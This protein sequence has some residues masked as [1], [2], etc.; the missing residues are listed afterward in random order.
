M[1]IMKM[2]EGKLG[3][4]NFVK[5]Y[6][7]NNMWGMKCYFY[8]SVV[9]RNFVFF[10]KNYKNIILNTDKKNIYHFYYSNEIN[11][12]R[13]D[14]TMSIDKDDKNIEKRNTEFKKKNEIKFKS[15]KSFFLG[16][17]CFVTS[18]FF[19][20]TLQKVPEG[21][22][23]LLENKKDKTV[24]PYIYDDLMTFFF[25]SIKYNVIFMRIIPIHK[26]YTNIYETYDKKKVRVK[27]E[28]KLKPKIPFVREIYS[29]FG[30]NYSTHFIKKELDIDI[31]NVIK[32]HKFDTFINSNKNKSD[33]INEIAADDIIDE[34]VDRFYD[35]SIFYKIVILDVLLS[36]EPINEEN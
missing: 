3:F 7:S 6:T 26:K 27:L 20:C 32:N 17:I 19:Y 31:K 25:N 4:M 2:K 9:K 11:K 35:T 12:E 33:Q 18:L 5:C 22:I 14:L 34:I 36:F 13:N 28:I 30:A 1:L 24:L 29:S 8:N 15:G 10:P 16:I 23:C 21:Y